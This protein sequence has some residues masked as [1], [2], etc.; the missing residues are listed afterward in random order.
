MSDFKEMILQ[1]RRYFEEGETKDLNFRM[2][3]LKTLRKVIIDNEEEIREALRKDL[4]KTPFEAYATEIGIVLEELSYTFKHLPKWV[5]R[6]RVRTP[7]TQFLATSFT[8]PEPHGI[9]LIMS[10][11]NY[12][13][14]LAMAPL[15]GA[16]A[17]GN[18]SVIKP[19]EYSFNTSV[20][21]EKL[22][23]EN[24]KEE[25]IT[26]VRGGREANKTLLDEKFD[27][28]FFTGSVAVGKTVMEAASKHLTPVTLELGGK[29]PCIVDETANI[30]LAAKR[31]IWG[32]LLNSGQTCVAPDYLLVHSSIKSKLIDKMKEYVVEFYGENPSKNEDY[33]KIINEKHFKRLQSLI[34]GEEIV[35]GGQFNE[36]TRQISPTIV[37]NVTWDSPVMVE[38]IFG[39]ILPVLEF[40]HLS[41]VISQINKHPKPLALYFFTTI[42]EREEQILRDISF[43]GGCINDT[44]VH[45]A[46]SYMPFGGVGESGMGGYH[47]KASFDTF[48]HQKSIMKRSNLLDIPFRYPPFKNK[49]SLVKKVMR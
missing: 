21:I 26:V 17:A 15:I 39:P 44:I 14:Q 35:F 12:P 8:Y 7:I 1:Q 6:K 27:H 33:P 19:S 48:S 10:P 49:L 32:K 34:L 31:I 9:T 24:F 45:L 16:I 37:H 38:E 25:F 30:D 11:W 29:S 28:I 13:F 23:K 2:E 22:I 42:K 40:E 36:E 4:N 3:K 18:C 43:G 20:V 47:G 5:K 41:E 46:T